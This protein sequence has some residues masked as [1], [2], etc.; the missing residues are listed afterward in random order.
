[1]DIAGVQYLAKISK[2]TIEDNGN[3]YQHITNF[4]FAVNYSIFALFS[5]IVQLSYT[6]DC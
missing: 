3:D 6:S 4:G 1:M 2:N 5:Q